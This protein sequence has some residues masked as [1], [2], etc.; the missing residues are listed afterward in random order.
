MDAVNKLEEAV[1]DLKQGKPFWPHLALTFPK[2]ECP[3]SELRTASKAEITSFMNQFF[4]VMGKNCEI[5]AILTG[6]WDTNISIKSLG[7]RAEELCK[8]YK[9]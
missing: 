4:T 6:Y 7:E 8:L 3:L 9:R 2:D 5:F 1:V